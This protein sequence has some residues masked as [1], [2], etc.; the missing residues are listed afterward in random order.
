MWRIGSDTTLRTTIGTLLVLDRPPAPDALRDRVAEVVERTPRLKCRPVDT[1]VP[2]AR[3]VWDDV[4]GLR[5]DDLIRHLDV[6][7]PGEPRQVLELMSLLEAMPFEPRLP[8]W[9]IT[10][11]EGLEGGRAAVYLRAHHVVADG[12]GGLSLIDLL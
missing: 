5:A 10:V 12:F 2:A 3:P 7:T 6:G 8:L 11:I 9:D 4:A 1:V